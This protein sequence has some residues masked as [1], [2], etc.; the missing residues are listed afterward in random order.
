MVFGCLMAISPTSYYS[1]LAPIPAAQ[2]DLS[3]YVSGWTSGYGIPETLQYLDTEYAQK[4]IVVFV[5]M[6]SGNPE[7]AII[8]A[9]ERKHIP[10]FYIS[11]VNDIAQVKEL[12]E[13]P[14]YF[15][16]RGPQYA[17]IFNY[18]TEVAKYKK[19]FGDEF[20]GV[21]RINK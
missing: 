10:V 19:P 11:Q 4:N 7:D 1:L 12:A 9:M 17:G 2:G 6:D 8:A 15:V 14:W 5:R 13:L 20:V 21:Y 18:L 3:Q 16:S